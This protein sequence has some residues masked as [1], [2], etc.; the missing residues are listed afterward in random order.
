MREPPADLYAIDFA[1]DR[2]IH[3]VTR[4]R[5]WMPAP[6]TLLITSLI[7]AQPVPAGT[8]V[9]PPP[10]TQPVHDRD[11][12]VFR[13]VLDNNPRM[14][15]INL[16][17]GWWM[18]FDT[19]HCSIYKL[20]QGEI[21]LTGA[22]YDTKH[23][24]QPKAKGRFV[25]SSPISWSIESPERGEPAR[26]LGYTLEADQVTLRWQEGSVRFE[27]SPRLA[28]NFLQAELVTQSSKQVWVHTAIALPDRLRIGIQAGGDIQAD[29]SWYSNHDAMIRI[30]LR[31]NLAEDFETT[32]EPK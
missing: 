18:A 4:R 19:V 16:G 30:D 9:D 2:L 22:V 11:P 15:I 24:P 32:K 23:G 20:W 12:W 28:G 5:N 8:P 6:L 25:V 26:W 27:L 10:S 31:E 21:E 13:C 14:L 7:Q 1:I 29:T 3:T 17:D